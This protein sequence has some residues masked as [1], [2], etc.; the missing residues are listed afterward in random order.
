[1]LQRILLLSLFICA[2]SSTTQAKVP[3]CQP[4]KPGLAIDQ[5]DDF[6]MNCIKQKSADLTVSRCLKIAGTMEY[7]FNTEEAKLI[8]LFELPKSAT[9]KEC[10]ETSKSLEYPDSGDHARWECLQRY[11]KTIRKKECLQVSESMSYPANKH[12]ASVF[13]HHELNP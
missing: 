8:C 12:R 7:S 2:T 1:M 9:L 6:R 10:I 5:R 3:S 4:S 11:S 13:C